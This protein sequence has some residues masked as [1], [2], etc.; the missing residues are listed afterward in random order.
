MLTLRLWWPE[1]Y[2]D[3]GQTEE[4][5][6]VETFVT[7]PP[8]S[9]ASSPRLRRPPVWQSGSLVCVCV[10]VCA[11]VLFSLMHVRASIKRNLTL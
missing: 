4:T 5:G 7:K 2:K 3:Q 6:G 9:S 10:F 11:F 8:E 1:Q